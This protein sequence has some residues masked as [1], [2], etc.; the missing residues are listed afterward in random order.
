MTR[1]GAA[2][3]SVAM[4][5]P[6]GAAAGTYTFTM[7]ASSA[8]GVTIATPPPGV[9]AAGT[10]VFRAVSPAGDR[11]LA[12]GGGALTTVA[13][14][15]EAFQGLSLPAIDQAGAVSFAAFLAAGG[16]T[17]YRASVP[18]AGAADGFATFGG[19]PAAG[20]AGS[21]VFQ[22]TRSDGHR[23][24]YAGTAGAPPTPVALAEGALAEL[25]LPAAGGGPVVTFRALL[26]GGGA[27]IVTAGAGVPPVILTRTGATFADFGDFP[28]IASDG[29]VAFRA[30][31]ATGGETIMLARSDAPAAELATTAAGVFSRFGHV[32]INAGRTVAFFAGFA[33]GGAGIF[34]GPDRVANRVI[35]IGDVLGTST[36][37]KL[38]FGRDGLSDAGHVAF[39]AELADGTTGIWRADPAD[40]RVTTLVLTPPVGGAG[41]PVTVTDTTRNRGTSP[42]G[43]SVTRFYFST[44]NVLDPS[45]V[46]IGARVVSALGAGSEETGSTTVTIPVTAATGAYSIIA[47]AG[48]TTK[49]TSYKIGP[50]LRISNTTAPSEAAPGASITVGASTENQGGGTAPASTTRFYFSADT[51]VDANDVALGSRAVPALAAG[52]IDTGTV[53]VA[54]PGHTAPGTYYVIAQADAGDVVPEIAEANN[55]RARAIVIA[56]AVSQVAASA[57]ATPDLVVSSLAVRP[58]LSGITVNDTTSNVGTG[59]APATGTMYYLSSDAVLDAADVP[60]FRRPVRALAAGASSSDSIGVSLPPETAGSW[61]LIARADVDGVVAETNE[62]N[63]TRAVAFTIGPDLKVP[64]MFLSSRDVTAGQSLI[65][66]DTVKNAGQITAPASVIRFYLSSEDDIHIRGVLLGSRA[67]PELCPKATDSAP[68]ELVIPLGTPPGRYRIYAVADAADAAL[69]LREEN[70]VRGTVRFNVH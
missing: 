15:G 9:N 49:A 5:A 45:D 33:D 50:D 28:A 30:M 56:T 23:G 67:V 36:V 31:L 27:A 24:I 53:S 20:E 10:V 1:L 64:T 57:V 17:L 43:A 2:L 29:T 18:I 19:L 35:Q 68:T 46:E 70:N 22:A 69:E 63:N 59:A 26:D 51:V 8:D 41:R 13:S 25:G 65:V 6:T 12:G 16:E 55:V 54:V 61:Y 47:R 48:D 42:V 11:L 14:V 3:V 37:R 4:L 58:S 21:V 66:I 40:V 32:A 62:G 34:T 38:D 52:A 60:L 39:Y 7:I 44:D